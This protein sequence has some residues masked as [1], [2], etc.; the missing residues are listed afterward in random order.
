VSMEGSVELAVPVADGDRKRNRFH[1]DRHTPE[2]RERFESITK[3]MLEKCPVAWSDTYG[4]HWVAAGARDVF[5]IARSDKVSSEHDVKGERR[6]YQ[7]VSP[8]L[9]PSHPRGGVSS[10]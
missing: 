5:K 3:D 8:S 10:R 2:Y 1:F 4:G 7:G 6:G 9:R